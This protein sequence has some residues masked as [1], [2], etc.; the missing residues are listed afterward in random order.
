MLTILK[1]EL[2][3]SVERAMYVILEVPKVTIFPLQF[4]YEKR[5]N[6]ISIAMPLQGNHISI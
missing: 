6:I 1:S 3:K 4:H 2:S 5:K